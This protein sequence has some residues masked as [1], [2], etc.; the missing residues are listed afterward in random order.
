MTNKCRLP[1]ARKSKGKGDIQLETSFE[2]R[3]KI[4]TVE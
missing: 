3:S 4:Q 2:I 1:T